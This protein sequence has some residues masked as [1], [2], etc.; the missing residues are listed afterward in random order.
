MG[1]CLVCHSVDVSVQGIDRRVAISSQ[2]LCHQ[3]VLLI[4]LVLSKHIEALLEQAVVISLFEV[5]DCHALPHKVLLVSVVVLPLLEKVAKTINSLAFTLLS[6]DLQLVESDLQ[7]LVLGKLTGKQVAADLVHKL[8]RVAHPSVE[9]FVGA[10]VMSSSEQFTNFLLSFVVEHSGTSPDCEGPLHV[11]AAVGAF[12]LPDLADGS[13]FGAVLVL[14]VEEAGPPSVPHP[15]LQACRV[16]TVGQVNGLLLDFDWFPS[17]LVPL[18]KSDTHLVLAEAVEHIHELSQRVVALLVKAAVGVEFVHCVL[19]PGVDHP[20]Q[21]LM[22]NFENDQFGVVLVVR[23]HLSAFA[24][25][26]HHAVVISA[27]QLLQFVA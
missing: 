21:F 13:V 17:L 22:Q 16:A 18:L 4:L 7:E 10:V 2:R 15:L 5:V 20:F 6:L 26:L 12:E 8:G 14:V 27:V 11:F 1:H 23:V 19:L 3:Q 25:D 9:S 24:R